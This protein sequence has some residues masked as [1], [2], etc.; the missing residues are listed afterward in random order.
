MF[1]FGVIRGE[2]GCEVCVGVFVRDKVGEYYR[3]EWVYKRDE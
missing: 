1:W 2:S 3:D